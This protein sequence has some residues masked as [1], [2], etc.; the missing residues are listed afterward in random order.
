MVFETCLRRRRRSR[1]EACCQ[2]A[3]PILSA[4]RSFT[5]ALSAY[6]WQE[7]STNLPPIIPQG[8]TD[9]GEHA[10]LEASASVQS[11]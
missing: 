9:P 6:W 10:E 8:E 4:E 1:V 3:P 2:A 11:R 5:L 7:P